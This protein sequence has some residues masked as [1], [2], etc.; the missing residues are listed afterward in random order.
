MIKLTQHLMLI[1]RVSLLIIK[2]P[3]SENVKRIKERWRVRRISRT[4]VESIYVF[5]DTSCET[6]TKTNWENSGMSSFI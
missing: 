4:F 3:F 1:L 6:Q 5:N 2:V